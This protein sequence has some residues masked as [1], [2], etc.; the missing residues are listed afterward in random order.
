ML[1]NLIGMLTFVRQ[2]SL[3]SLASVCLITCVFTSLAALRL[4]VNL[5]G[6]GVLISISVVLVDVLVS[7]LCDSCRSALGHLRGCPWGVRSCRGRVWYSTFSVHLWARG[8]RS[9]LS[10][11]EAVFEVL[12]IVIWLSVHAQ[13]SVQNS[14]E[15]S[16]AGDAEEVEVV[17]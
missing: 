5:C 9:S 1:A 14:L 3:V 16:R 10:L 4:N 7:P 6:L 8:F 11:G 15:C 13:L 2:R 12:L 17:L